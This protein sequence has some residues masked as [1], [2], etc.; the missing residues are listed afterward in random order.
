VYALFFLIATELLLCYGG[1]DAKAILSLSTLLLFVVPLVTVVYAT[2]HLY[3]SREF[4]ELLLA[5]PVRRGRLYA[6][7]YVGITL[8]LT[9]ALAVGIAIPVVVHGVLMENGLRAVFATVLFVATALTCVFTAIAFLIALWCEDPM[10]G[11]GAA[12]AA[13]LAFSLVYDALVLVAVATSGN[14]PLERP[15]LAAMF[16]N[17]IDLARVMLLMQFD[18]SALMGYTGAVF[19]RFFGG[20]GAWA[21]AAAMAAWVA[22]PAMA[23]ARA[24]RRKDF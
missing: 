20:A 10:R 8:A 17:P 14:W 16:F 11:L 6:G 23:G 15:V 12:I 5:Q 2:V 4:V 19:H 18:S 9:L 21:A 1:G 24:F 22:V 3:Q 7:L 13:W